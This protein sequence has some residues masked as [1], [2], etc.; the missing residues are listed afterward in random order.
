LVAFVLLGLLNSSRVITAG[1]ACASFRDFA[2]WLLFDPCWRFC[3]K[4]IW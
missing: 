3:A 4:W 2:C 1:V